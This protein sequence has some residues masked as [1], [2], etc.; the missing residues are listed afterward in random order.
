[1]GPLLTY[2]DPSFTYA[3]FKIVLRSVDFPQP[4]LPMSATLSQLPNSK[5]MSLMIGVWVSRYSV[6]DH[7]ADTLASLRKGLLTLLYS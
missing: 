1:M 7:I 4:T 2:I 3:S 6:G 5:L